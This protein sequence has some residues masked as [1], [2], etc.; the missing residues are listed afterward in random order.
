MLRLLAKG[1]ARC[2]ISL[3]NLSEVSSL[4]PPEIVRKAFV[5]LGSQGQGK[6]I[7]LCLILEAKFYD[8]P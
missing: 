5:F 7:I 3:L 2:Q 4:Y 1:R 8:D 6:L